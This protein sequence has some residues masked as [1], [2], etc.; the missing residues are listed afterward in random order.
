[1]PDP[2]ELNLQSLGDGFV[3]LEDIM[4]WKTP[5][6]PRGEEMGP[7]GELNS[8]EEKG[9]GEGDGCADALGDGDSERLF[10]ER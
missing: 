7:K 8:D 10:D 3:R 6:E 5:G 4:C 2:R 1:M 9:D